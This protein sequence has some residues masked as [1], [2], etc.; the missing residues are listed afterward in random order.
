[1]DAFPGPAYMYEYEDI[2]DHMSWEDSPLFANII[3]TIVID[4]VAVF[5]TSALVFTIVCDKSVR[6]VPHAWFVLNATLGMLLYTSVDLSGCIGRHGLL[7]SWTD[8]P[9]F[10]EMLTALSHGCLVV[11]YLSTMMT[12]LERACSVLRMVYPA[13]GFGVILSRILL[14]LTWLIGLGFGAAITYFSVYWM[15]HHVCVTIVQKIPALCNFLLTVVSL[16][17]ITG[18]ILTSILWLRSDDVKIEDKFVARAPLLSNIITTSLFGFMMAP[19]VVLFLKRYG[20]VDSDP[21]LQKVAYYCQR[22]VCIVVPF[23]WLVG[24]EDFRSACCACCKPSRK[25]EN[26]FLLEQRTPSQ[27]TVHRETN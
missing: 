24:D 6:Q 16:L 12:S 2:P 18:A 23:A 20:D 10:C 8:V 27:E 3:A 21:I 17:V 19:T 25:G 9:I 4:S 13:S 15:P 11:I 26:Q 7:P 22:S 1:M 5:M 14:P